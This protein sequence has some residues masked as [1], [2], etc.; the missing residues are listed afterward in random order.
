MRVGAISSSSCMLCQDFT[1]D[2]IVSAN[3]RAYHSQTLRVV[4]RHSNEGGIKSRLEGLQLFLPFSQINKGPEHTFMDREVC[5]CILMNPHPE[6]RRL[7]KRAHVQFM[8]A[9]TLLFTSR[10]PS[11]FAHERCR[12]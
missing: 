10:K 1:K 8:F 6:R 2:V 11:M 4:F 7:N 12:Q 5:L 3:K 9:C